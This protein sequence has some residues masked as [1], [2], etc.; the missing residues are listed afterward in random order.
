MGP[1]NNVIVKMDMTVYQLSDILQGNAVV[2]LLFNK[3]IHAFNDVISNAWSYESV[4]LLY[5]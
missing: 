5:I 2:N 1:S 3:C 4:N